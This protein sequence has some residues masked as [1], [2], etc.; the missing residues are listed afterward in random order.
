MVVS[1]HGLFRCIT[2]S[3]E[4]FANDSG[5]VHPAYWFKRRYTALSCGERQLGNLK[6]IEVDRVKVRF[7]GHEGDEGQVGSAVA[8]K[9]SEVRGVRSTRRRRSYGG[10]ACA[11]FATRARATLVVQVWE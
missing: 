2:L 7:R 9:R 5:A 1:G 4:V 6:Y 8:C 11:L 10:I 3:D